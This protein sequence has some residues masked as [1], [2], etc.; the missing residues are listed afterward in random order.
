M[1]VLIL[2]IFSLSNIL[3]FIFGAKV[4]QKVAKG[5]EVELPKIDPMQAV[6]E[7]RAKKEAEM[8]QEKFN[9]I[10]R[11]IDIYDGT[12]NGQKEVR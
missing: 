9:T 12:P 3:C 11:N 10:Q 4:G 2:A 8:E 7:H 1:E 6:R 5:E